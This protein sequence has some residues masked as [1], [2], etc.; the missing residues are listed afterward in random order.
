MTLYTLRP[1][2]PVDK[3]A[4]ARLLVESWG[5]V[6][7]YAVALGGLLDAS[8]LPGWIV[9]QQRQVVGLLTYRINGATLDIVTIN[10]FRTGAGVGTALVEKLA[11][12]A[13]ALGARRIRVATT[14]DNTDALRFYQRRG[15][16]LTGVRPDAMTKARRKHKPELPEIGHH[17]IP[18]RDEV[19]LELDVT[20]STG[21]R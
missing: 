10:A 7:V 9:E 6:M 19:D 5:S 8:T 16:R 2:E 20:S 18:I 4:V 3:P 12:Q 14:N 17:G 1:I 13:S 15:F 11:G 21:R